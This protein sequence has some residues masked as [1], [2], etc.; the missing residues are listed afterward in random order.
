MPTKEYLSVYAYG[1][2]PIQSSRRVDTITGEVAP[3]WCSGF[4]HY[5]VAEDLQYHE[6][7]KATTVTPELSWITNGHLTVTLNGPRKFTIQPKE[8]TPPSRI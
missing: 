4:L 5:W 2:E 6:E 8:K 3:Y 7:I 1:I